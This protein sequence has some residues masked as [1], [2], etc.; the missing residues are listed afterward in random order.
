MAVEDLR[1]FFTNERSEEGEDDYI[2]PPTP[3]PFTPPPSEAALP[4]P[5]PP[6]L[7]PGLHGHC[8]PGPPGQNKHGEEAVEEDVPEEEEGAGVDTSSYIQLILIKIIIIIK[9]I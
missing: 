9:D 8:H 6:V 5:P 4:P 3:L 2:H 1:G 7:P